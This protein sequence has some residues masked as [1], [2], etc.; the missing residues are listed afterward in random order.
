MDEIF[1]I[2]E[3]VQEEAGYGTDLIWGNCFDETLGDK[4]SVTVIAT[5]F[6]HNH[7]NKVKL[8]DNAEKIV[9]SL[10]DE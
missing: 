9:V 1:E 8:D 2:T 7:K 10:E 3:F 5:G 6:E 4:I